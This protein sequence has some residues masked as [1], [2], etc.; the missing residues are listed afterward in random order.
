MRRYN[1]LGNTN[2]LYCHGT[3]MSY[4]INNY[5]RIIPSWQTFKIYYLKM[6]LSRWIIKNGISK[7]INIIIYS[8][9]VF[10]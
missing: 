10:Y 5:I 8:C 1:M 6:I 4:Y 3:F 2:D 7:N 9:K